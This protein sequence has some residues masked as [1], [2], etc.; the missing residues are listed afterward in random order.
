M[1]D[2]ENAV[3]RIVSGIAD[4]AA[5]DWD[6][7]ARGNDPDVAPGRPANPFIMHAFLAALE[8]SG[9]ASRETGWLPRHLLLEDA[10]GRLQGCMPCFLKSHS[11]GEYVF[12]HGWANAYARAGG[13]YYP[14]LQSAVPFSV[15][16]GMFLGGIDFVFQELFRFLLGLSGGGL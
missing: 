15:I 2:V 12:D 3:V 10:R 8:A 14:K 9:S 11:Y 6:A 4:V 16:V 5:S 1:G 13:R 7:C